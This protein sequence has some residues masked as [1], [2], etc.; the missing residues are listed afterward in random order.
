[1]CNHILI[2]GGTGTLGNPV[3]RSLAERGIKVRILTRSPER[4]RR[5]FPEVVEI[6]GGSPVDRDQ[7]QKA[8]AGCD[9]VHISLPEDS[10]LVA[11]R[12][13]V[14]LAGRENVE[15]ISYVSGT[16]VREDNRWF[17][18]IDV[19]LQAEALLRQSG[20][21]HTVFCPTWVMEVFHKFVQGDRAAVIAGKNPPGIH[22]FAAADFGRMAAAAY[23]N[24]QALGKRL[25]IHGPES[26]ALEN[27][28]QAF[29]EACYP[30]V[31]VM[32]L[33]LWQARLI[34]KITGKM[35]S[36]NRL[37]GY[38]DKV[39]ELGDPSEANDLLGPPL[40]TLDDWIKSQRSILPGNEV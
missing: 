21:P 39:G 34:A 19:K 23:D 6:V 24:D 29:L 25:F 2:L 32:R 9:A 3:A 10:E 14:D 4:A 36:A 12:H 8:M 5:I 18:M 22:F 11:V 1:M 17:S 31:R 7:L 40:S 38:F 33:K 26:I 28:L 15:Q 27:A 35:D 30:Q 20:I 37:I 13:V 16:S